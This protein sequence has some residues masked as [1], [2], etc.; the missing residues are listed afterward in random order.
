MSTKTKDEPKGEN[1]PDEKVKQAKRS[2]SGK[3][4]EGKGKEIKK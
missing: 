2:E 3:R 1:P 4:F